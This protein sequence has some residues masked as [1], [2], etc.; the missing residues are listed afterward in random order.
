MKKALF[1][2]LLAFAVLTVHPMFSSA[3]NAQEVEAETRLTV[4][5]LFTSQG[6][7]S[8][9]PA[10]AILKTMRDRPG[11]LTLSWAVDYWDRLGWEDTFATSY[12]SMRQKAYN[13]RLRRGGVFTPQMIMDGR[14]QC[15]ASKT[16]NV[17]KNVQKARAI[18]RPLVNLVLVQEGESLTLTLPAH[19]TLKMVAIRVVWYQA[20]AVIEIGDGENQGRT[21]H[22]TN[23]VRSTDLLD[24]WDGSAQNRTIPVTAPEGTDHVAILLQDEYGHGPIVGAASLTL[25]AGS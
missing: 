21:L 9:P 7:S 13:K 12:N 24:E 23:I 6:C 11:I 22:Y 1:K 15:V 19:E 20:D 2:F 10:D 17:R 14:V 4:I 25:H 3:T 8:C 5:E 16:K 18:G